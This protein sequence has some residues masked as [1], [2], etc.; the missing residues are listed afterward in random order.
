MS[1]GR[2]VRCGAPTGPKALQLRCRRSVV[3]KSSR[4]VQVKVVYFVAV[5]I[6]RDQTNEQTN[7]QTKLAACCPRG[8]G[9]RTAALCR[10]WCLLYCREFE[11]WRISRRAER[12]L[13]SGTK[14]RRRQDKKS[15][16][17]RIPRCRTV[18]EVFLS[19][20]ERRVSSTFLPLA[21]AL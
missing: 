16:R 14:Q 4:R 17:V 13:W 6:R 9:S 21:A 20:S 19:V 5:V 18:A 8:T 2:A 10:R 11:P 12:G 7:K 1:W 3:E 15:V